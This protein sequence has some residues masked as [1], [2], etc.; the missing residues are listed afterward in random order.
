MLNPTVQK[1]CMALHALLFLK[2]GRPCGTEVQKVL[3]LETSVSEHLW[4][5]G[6][7]AFNRILYYTA[8]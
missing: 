8:L 3:D 2:A 6:E 5:W 7:M 1:D 4:G